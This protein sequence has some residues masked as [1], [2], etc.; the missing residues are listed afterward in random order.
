MIL[1][2]LTINAQHMKFMGIPIDG[3]VNMFASKLMSKGFSISPKNKK[4]GVGKRLMKGRFYDQEVDLCIIYIPLT[5]IVYGVVIRFHNSN[6]TI[7]ERM[8]EDI[9]D[10]V[11]EKYICKEEEGKTN[12]GYDTT[13]YYIYEESNQNK[14]IGKINMGVKFDDWDYELFLVY[15]DEQNALKN[16][17]IKDDDI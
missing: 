3:N 12:A 15:Q 2:S 5:K 17:Q 4:T 10:S 8:M 7:L 6:R 9:G 14:L 1:L 13:I 11:K 16:K